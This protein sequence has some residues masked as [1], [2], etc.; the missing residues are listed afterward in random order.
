MV[1]KRLLWVVLLFAGSTFGRTRFADGGLTTETP[2]PA[3]SLMVVGGLAMIG[4]GRVR[5]RR[6]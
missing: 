5:R 4:L 2:E 3:A 6:P 1:L